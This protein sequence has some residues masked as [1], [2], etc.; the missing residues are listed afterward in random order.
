MTD[1]NNKQQEPSP[2]VEINL[3]G[4]ELGDGLAAIQQVFAG[5][6]DAAKNAVG[7]ELL[8]NFQAG[9][10]LGRVATCLDQ[11]AAQLRTEVPS[12]AGKL[13]ELAAYRERLGGELEGSKFAPEVT[14]LAERLDSALSAAR[15]R[16]PDVVAEA[17]G[18]FRAAA[19]SAGPI[20]GTNPPSGS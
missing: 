20:P 14:A 12:V 19:N 3:D 17:G 18:Y 1:Q 6:A 8:K 9:Q 16:N 15:D 10:W 2:Q 13:G 11:T 7:P 4:T 5:L